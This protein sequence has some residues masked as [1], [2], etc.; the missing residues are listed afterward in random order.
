MTSCHGNTFYITGPFWQIHGNGWLVVDILMI[1][2]WMMYNLERAL[3]PRCILSSVCDT[4]I[5]DGW[6][7]NQCAFN[8]ILRNNTHGLKTHKHNCRNTPM[9]YVSTKCLHQ[10]CWHS[11]ELWHIQSHNDQIRFWY[12]RLVLECLHD[13]SDYQSQLILIT[14]LTQ[15]KTKSFHVIDR[16]IIYLGLTPMR[17]DYTIT[18]ESP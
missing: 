8:V 4:F 9:E 7:Q 12:I 15:A 11:K 18:I 10:Q 13:V 3:F 14:L 1:S 5:V 6:W 2:Q 17:Y 16:T